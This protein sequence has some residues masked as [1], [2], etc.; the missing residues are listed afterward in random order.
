MS[1][2]P[3][4]HAPAL[5]ALVEPDLREVEVRL[6]GAVGDSRGVV[7]DLTG[8]LARA[9]G[10]RLRP[11][12]TLLCSQLGMPGRRAPAEVL[13][14]ATAVE[15][16]HLASLYHDDV[17]DSAPV[18]RG[19]PAAQR[20][21]GNDRAILAGDL[22][23]ARA[24]QLVA[25]LGDEA[26]AYHARTF[27]RLCR[28]QLNETFG[29]EDGQDPVAFYLSVLADKTGALVATAAHFGAY[30]SGADPQVTRVVAQFG[31]KIGVAF[32]LADDVIDLSGPGASTGKVAGTDLRDGVDTLPVLLLRRRQA[33][34]TLDAE[35]REIL[36]GLAGDLSS[37][38]ALAR[39][40]EQ[41]RR[42]EVVPETRA[43]ARRMVQEAVA[44][45][46][47]IPSGDVREGLAA[48]AQLMVNR[49]S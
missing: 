1:A 11:L 26:V 4:L 16:T 20:V 6:R 29:P 36:Q 35:G 12:L 27:E 15:L 41:L 7:S 8:H 17:M 48:F 21:W 22:L 3:D 42:H 39:V 14:A 19:V 38:A 25:S 32:Q 47:A 40:V 46:D 30:F 18:R 33:E 45:L 5:Q 24:S 37:D 44:S 49:R 31:E 43:L 9:G 2:L 10:K 34:G 23:F 13:T 28:G